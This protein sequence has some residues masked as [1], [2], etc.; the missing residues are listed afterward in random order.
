MCKPWIA[1]LVAWLAVPALAI[2]QA[3]TPLGFPQTDPPQPGVPQM[4]PPPTPTNPVPQPP[5]GFGLPSAV[6]QQPT[7]GAWSVETYP[8]FHGIP[9]QPFEPPRM[10]ARADMLIWWL[11][12]QPN[13]QPLLK[14]A[15]VATVAGVPTTV[16]GPADQTVLGQ[17]TIPLK[18][19]IGTRLTLGYWFDYDSCFGGEVSVFI[20]AQN[21]ATQT[22]SADPR[23]GSPSLARPYFDVN[24][25]TEILSPV[26]LAGLQTG[27]MTVAIN[28]KVGGVEGNFLSLLYCHPEQLRISL[29]Y[30]GRYLNLSES[31]ELIS[32]T[33][34]LPGSA[35]LTLLRF[36]SVPLVP[37]EG[38][39]FW[40]YFKTRNQ[41]AGPQVG[42]RSEW[43]GKNWYFKVQGEIAFGAGV[44][45]VAA[46][47]LTLLMSGPGADVI[48]SS[49]GGFFTGPGN[50]GDRGRTV[51]SM[52]PSLEAQAS[53][54]IL[55]Y[56]WADL[57][58]TFLAMTSTVRP[59]LEIDPALNLAGAAA[60]VGPFSS[61]GTGAANRPTAI[62]N[63][64]VF[65][66]Y[67]LSFGL[68]LTW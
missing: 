45:S 47:G 11:R 55:P 43:F 52:V 68:R 23:T 63:E 38:L 48:N 2:A 21:G 24:R 6:V 56:V 66:A 1:I 42:L 51:F 17:N 53:Y 64:Q 12:D 49:G 67:G 65:W 16:D 54:Q 19:L 7:D 25:N 62:F 57:G 39:T 15:N 35:G 50:L 44:Q 10:W 61:P 59:G 34:L 58:F 26:A 40:D 46:D 29:T 31:M 14:I 20:L 9:V 33:N 5:I 30:G 41:F 36:D 18:G 27:N 60:Q 37:P 8:D 13:P 22:Y 28:S 32:N 4:L 3:P